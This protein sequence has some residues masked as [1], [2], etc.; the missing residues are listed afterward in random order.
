MECAH[1]RAIYNTIRKDFILSVDEH[2]SPDRN[3]RRS[4]FYPSGLA[5]ILARTVL[6][7]PVEEDWS[8][9]EP[10]G[11]SIFGTCAPD[12]VNPFMNASLA[13]L[14]EVCSVSLPQN[15]RNN[16]PPLKDIIRQLAYP[17]SRDT[18]YILPF[19]LASMALLC[20]VE[21]HAV[22]QLVQMV[23]DRQQPDGSWLDDTIISATAALALQRGGMAPRYD[24]RTWL[25]REKRPDGSWAAVS[26]EVWEASYALRTGEYPDSDKLVHL[27]GKCMHVNSWWGFSRYAVPDADDTA[28]ACCAL[29]P[30]L[31]DPVSRALINV[32]RMQNE[33]GGWGAFPPVEGVVPEEK[34]TGP[35][36]DT[37]SE[38]TCHVLEALQK[39]TI[40]NEAFEK[41]I[42][43]LLSRQHDDGHWSASWWNSDV[44]CTAECALL[45]SRNHHVEAASRALDWLESRLSEPVNLVENAFMIWAFC[46]SPSAYAS[47]LGEA[48]DRFVEHYR[49]ERSAPTFNFTYFAGLLDPEVYRQSVMLS[50]L[51]AFLKAR[52]WR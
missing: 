7:I 21:G 48:V 33:S 16:L 42:A 8:E 32:Q 4:S 41:G 14:Q 5:T 43:Y 38:I 18:S 35:P 3:S 44:Y 20:M 37:F 15:V 13:I 45:L 6:G 36:R 19:H 22:P 51:Q 25:E 49:T 1:V 29:T 40:F 26:G 46:A 24:V 47:S 34:V 50:S 11:R 52:E 39:N 28:V 2:L 9:F 31:P 23:H 27:L 17:Y 10:E 30:Y 12:E